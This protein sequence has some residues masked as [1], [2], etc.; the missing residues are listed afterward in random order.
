MTVDLVRRR[1]LAAA[2]AL[3][4]SGVLAQP[5]WPS[6]AVRLVVPFPPAGTSDVAARLVS[7][8]LIKALGQ[9]VIVENRAGANGNIGMAEV[10]RAPMDGHT[11]VVAVSGTLA[12]NR[13]LY[14]KTTFDVDKDFVPVSL[15]LRSPLV[16]VVPASLG[17]TSLPQLVALAKARPK[18][19]AYGSPAL[20][21]T[22]HL[23][24]ELLA[25]RAGV[26]LVHIPYKGSAPM[27]QDLM[28]GQFQMAVDTL[29][30]S[31]PHIQSGKL[32]ALAV[33]SAKAVAALPNVPTVASVLPGFEAEGWIAMMATANTPQPV[34]ERMSGQ[35]DEILRGP[36]LSERWR[37]MGVDPVGG[38]PDVLRAFIASESRKWK[39]V[40]TRTGI[41]LE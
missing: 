20:A 26:E 13:H 29:A 3:G 35:M 23:A 15:M 2:L 6:R 11:F 19:V 4:A 5:A 14:P 41:K 27:L 28:A 34:V 8:P 16:V 30:S 37:Q 22:S 17:V 25:L 39:E 21:S 1:G 10:A 12:V 9:P 38:R 31:M 18:S 32:L 36:A 7:E 33:T 24:A 40:V